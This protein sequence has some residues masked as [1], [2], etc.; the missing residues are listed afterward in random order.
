[1]PVHIVKEINLVLRAFRHLEVANGR[2]IKLEQIAHLI[3]RSVEEV[4]HVLSLNEHIASLDT[5]L[6][7]DP[8]HTIAD[9]IADDNAIDPESLLQA[10]EVGG[11]VKQWV[12]QLP[13]KQRWVLERRYGLGGGD[14]CTL[15]DIATDLNLTRERVRQIQIEALDQLR[16]VIKRGGVVRDNLL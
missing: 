3:D 11:L 5:P 2:E 16:R 8:N 4:R 15:E 6:E 12:E 7:I 13:D 10:N 1:L 14:V 9:A